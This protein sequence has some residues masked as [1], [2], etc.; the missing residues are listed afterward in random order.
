MKDIDIEQE[1]CMFLEKKLVHFK[2]YQ[3]FTEKMTHIMCGKEKNKEIQGL[4]SRR[5]TCIGAIEKIN[6]AMEKIFKKGSAGLSGIR[7]QYKSLIDSY[8]TS[9]KDIMMQIDLMD[10]ELVAVVAEQRDNIKS[11]LLEMRNMRQAARGYKSNMQYPARFL[12]TRK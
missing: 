6:A 11:D 9:I 3:S 4:I 12:D 10:R 8:M 5:Q 1:Y 7:K 2:Q